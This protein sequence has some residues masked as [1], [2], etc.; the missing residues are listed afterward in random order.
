MPHIVREL[1]GKCQ[2]IS[3]CLESGHPVFTLYTLLYMSVMSFIHVVYDIKTHS[4]TVY[5]N[6]ALSGLTE[7]IWVTFMRM[8]VP[9]ALVVTPAS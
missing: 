7:Y 1:S 2:G 4:S 8:L 3:E 9:G 6:P 5:R